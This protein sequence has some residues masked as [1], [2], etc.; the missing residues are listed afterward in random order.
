MKT[1]LEAMRGEFPLLANKTYL[2]SGSYCALANDVKRAFEAY[3]DDRLAVGANWDVWVAKNEAVRGLVARLLHARPDEIAVTA[4]VSAGLNAI[5]SAIDFSGPRNK[6]VISDFEFPTNAQIW[7]AQEPRN[8]EVVHV[9]ADE[10]GYIP[11]EQFERAIDDRTALVAVTHVCFRNGAKL[12]I[13]GIGRIARARGAKILFDCYQSVGSVDI[14]VTSMEVD[15]LVGGMLKYLLG[16]AGIGFLYVRDA[17]VR[18]LLPTHTGWFAQEN[19]T[20]MDITANRPSPT[21][22]RFEAGTPPVV[23]CYAAEAGLELL[24]S[25]GTP[26]IEARIRELTRRCIER[27]AAIGWPT[28][29]PRDDNRR[30]ATVA[31]PSRDSAG[32]ADA[33]MKRDIVTSYRD[34]NVR[35]SFHFYNNDQDIDALITA[36]D[37][38]KPRFAPQG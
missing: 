11:L 30:G 6:V 16:T 15:F 29:T 22:R 31:I 13:E 28:V 35:A 20:A 9:R 1:T 21:A 34:A 32:L 8:A 7:H 23:N 10:S 12:D 36:L 3:M 17:L 2:N 27:L 14:D 24:L 19:I 38:L 26:A 33:L 4:S 25:I 37:A 18:E 5:A